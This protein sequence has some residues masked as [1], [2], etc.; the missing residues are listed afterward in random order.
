M[1][2]WC[3][4]PGRSDDFAKICKCVPWL[5]DLNLN[6]RGGGE[7]EKKNRI[8]FFDQAGVFIF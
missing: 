8:T 1:E 2:V 7:G 6:K 4:R 3:D 5:G